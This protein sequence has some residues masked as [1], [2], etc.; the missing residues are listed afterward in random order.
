MIRHLLTSLKRSSRSLTQKP[1]KINKDCLK[2]LGRIKIQ[3]P[4]CAEVFSKNKWTLQ[5][6][7]FTSNHITKKFSVLLKEKMSHNYKDIQTVPVSLP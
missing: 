4:I 3:S 7:S 1:W 6:S 2:S 5:T